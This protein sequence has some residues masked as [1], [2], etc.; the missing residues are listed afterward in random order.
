M[1][2]AIIPITSKGIPLGH[3]LLSP[4]KNIGIAIRI[5]I[6]ASPVIIPELTKI[7][8][9]LFSTLDAIRPPMR[10]GADNSI[11]RYMPTATASI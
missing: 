4:D 9:F 7:P 2:N 10:I 6:K 11:G 1:Q 5:P 8:L 3:Q